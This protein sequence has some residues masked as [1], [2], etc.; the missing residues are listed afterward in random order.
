MRS[1]VAVPDSGVFR[2]R[3][4][5]RG[6]EPGIIWRAKIGLFGFVRGRCGALP[7]RKGLG[8]LGLEL[9]KTD[10]TGGAEL[11][12]GT[13]GETRRGLAVVAQEK[14]SGLHAP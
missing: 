4:F 10:T 11:Y 9:R 8:M 14:K 12:V 13:G 5:E 7:G 6:F 1:K 2:R 3:T